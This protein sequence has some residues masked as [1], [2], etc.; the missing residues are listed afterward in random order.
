MCLSKL[1]PFIILPTHQ[2]NQVKFPVS[3]LEIGKWLFYADHHQ[4]VMIPANAVH[5]DSN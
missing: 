4:Q 2:Y 5:G 1:N 3:S